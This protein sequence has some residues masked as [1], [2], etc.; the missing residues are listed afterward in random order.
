[1][2]IPR[3]SFD[4]S[5]LSDPDIL[6]LCKRVHLIA[7]GDHSR[8]AVTLTIKLKD[9]QVRSRRVTKVRGTP[10]DPPTKA[11]VYEKFALLTRHCPRDTM[12]SAAARLAAGEKFF[13]FCINGSAALF[14]PV[15]LK[16]PMAATTTGSGFFAASTASIAS[17]V[18]SVFV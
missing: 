2:A 3:F 8:D 18:A 6:S 4:Q 5:A 7:D 10:D 15:S 1:M 9:G 12:V 16:A 14:P 11:D 17:R 13:Q